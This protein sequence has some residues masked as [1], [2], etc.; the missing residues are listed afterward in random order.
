MQRLLFVNLSFLKAWPKPTL[1]PFT[2]E[3]SAAF[4]L[5]NLIHPHHRAQTSL[6]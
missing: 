5:L 6:A 4:A 2:A 1:Q 3:V